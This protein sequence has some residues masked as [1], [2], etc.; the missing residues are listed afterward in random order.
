MEFRRVARRPTYKE[1]EKARERRYNIKSKVNWWNR[2]TR[3][4]N[5]W[6]TDGRS[7]SSS[8]AAVPSQRSSR[9][10]GGLAGWVCKINVLVPWGGVSK[11]G[12][13]RLPCVETENI[14]KM[15]GFDWNYFLLIWRFCC[16]DETSN[17]LVQTR[18]SV[19]DKSA[20]I[21]FSF[22]F[23]DCGLLG[24]CSFSIIHMT[25][26][27]PWSNLEYPQLR[28][29]LHVWHAMSTAFLTIM[30]CSC[31]TIL[32]LTVTIEYWPIFLL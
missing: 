10:V 23:V 18:P 3:V 20:L 17:S 14:L 30:T 22:G 16:S 13:C 11:I 21:T 19:A 12:K 6:W 7:R 1:E 5:W 2:W 26:E 24:H 31:R 4:K 25:S 9:S 29:I 27:S 15:S 28:T 32:L 8:R